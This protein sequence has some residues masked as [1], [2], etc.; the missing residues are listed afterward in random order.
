MILRCPAEVHKKIIDVFTVCRVCFQS[1]SV[2]STRNRSAERGFAQLH[3]LDMLVHDFPAFSDV[4][5]L[6]QYCFLL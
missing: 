6:A 1:T 3:P 5:P 4:I 2:Y